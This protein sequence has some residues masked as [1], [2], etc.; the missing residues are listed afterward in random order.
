VVKD[1]NVYEVSN[2]GLKFICKLG[3][4]YPKTTIYDWDSKKS[5]KNWDKIMFDNND[6]KKE[7]QE[8]QEQMMYDDWDKQWRMY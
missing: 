4:D 5:G 8:A 2:I 1:N 7:Q 3:I 6:L